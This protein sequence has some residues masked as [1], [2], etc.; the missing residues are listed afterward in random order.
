MN[1]LGQFFLAFGIV[2]HFGANATTVSCVCPRLP[3][4]GLLAAGHAA[5]FLQSAERWVPT[6]QSSG[7]R[8]GHRCHFSLPKLS[9]V[10]C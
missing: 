1:I 7:P 4:A 5:Q 8:V 10:F 2:Y 3:P 6:A 9:F